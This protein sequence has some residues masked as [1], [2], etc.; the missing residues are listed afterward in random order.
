MTFPMIGISV[1]QVKTK[2]R[3]VNQNP[4]AYA[5]AII[6]AGGL[7]ILIPNEFPL[8]QIPSLFTKIDG[9][10]LSGGGDLDVVLYHGLAHPSLFEV[11]Q[12]RDALEIALVNHAR[13]IHKPVFGICRGMQV[14]NVAMGGT[15]FVD[16]PSHYP[17]EITH[18]IPAAKGR[19]YLAHEVVLEADTTIRKIIGLARFEVN[20]FHHQ[21][22]KK[23]A[24]DLKVTARATDGLIEAV[25][26]A[27]ES[28]SVIGV[29]WHPECLLK[30]ETSKK[31]FQAF[32]SAC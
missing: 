27:G 31:L 13:Q 9:L 11:S 25:E 24:P 7:P 17:S 5:E 30:M 2:T 32:V 26:T 6:Q 1:S 20:S 4:S 19:D 14:I 28:F 3:M 22:I 12:Q 16:I 15:L 21:A 23:I 18:G 29:Q 10:L 8:D